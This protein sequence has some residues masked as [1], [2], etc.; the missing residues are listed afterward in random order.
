MHLAHAGVAVS[1]IGIT[2]VTGYQDEKDLRMVAGDEVRVGGYTFTLRD[3]KDVNG[4][5]YVAAQADIDV[6][7]QDG[8]VWRTLGPQKRVYLA[9]QNAMTETAIDSGVFRDLYVSLG[10]PLGNDAWQVRIQYKPFV[11]W[12]W[13]GAILM[14]LGGALAVS[15]PRYARVVVRSSA[16]ARIPERSAAPSVRTGL[17]GARS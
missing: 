13:L 14:A 11:D 8:S 15:D 7:R 1:I 5:N 10:E 3:V 6:S 2:M 17:S 9:S 12:I 4:P 16:P